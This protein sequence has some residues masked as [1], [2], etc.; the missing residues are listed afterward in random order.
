MGLPMGWRW[1]T[2]RWGR[3]IEELSQQEGNDPRS[4]EKIEILFSYFPDL[5]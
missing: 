4:F 3:R 1:A 5:I 2:E